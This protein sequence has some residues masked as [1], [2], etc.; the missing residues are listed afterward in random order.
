MRASVLFE[1]GKPLQVEE[2]DLEAPREGEV[3]VHMTA[4]GVCHSCLHAAD[5]SW[6]GVPVPIVLAVP[7]CDRG[8]RQ[9]C[10]L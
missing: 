2:L 5:G 7:W 10:L 4:S 6:K 9:G 3:L 8:G 1:Q